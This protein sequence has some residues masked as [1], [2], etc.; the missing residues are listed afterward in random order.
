MDSGTKVRW[1]FAKW[2]DEYERGVDEYVQ[3][4]FA[5]KSQGNQICCPCES[6]HYRFW[7]HEGVVRDQLICNGFVPR[8][9]KLSELGISIER[10]QTILDNDEG[11]NPNDFNDDIVGLLHDARDDFRKGPNDE[12]KKFFKLVEEGQEELYLSCKNHSKHSFMIRIFILKCDHKPTNVA[13]GDILELIREVLPDAKL[14]ASFNE[15]KS[16]LKVLG[17]DYTKIDACPNDCMIYWEEHENATSCHVCETPRWKSN[18][19]ENG[20]QNENGKTYKIPQNILRYFP[21]KKRLQRLFM[22]QETARY[23][24]WH[25]DGREN[26]HLL[27]HPVDGQAWKEFDSLYP[28]F[29]DDPRN[30]RLG[31]A[32]DGF[33]PFNSMSIVHSTWPVMLINYNLPP[34]MIM[35]PEY[36]MLALLIP[37]PSSPGNDID[38]YLQPLIK[39]LKDLWEFGLETYDASTNQ[40]FDIHVAL[41]TIVSDFPGYAM[42]SGWSTKGYL[43]CPECHYETDSEWLLYSGKN[44][45]RAN[46]ISQKNKDNV[47]ARQDLVELNLM[48]ELQPIEF[49]DGSEEF[50]RSRFWMSLEQKHK[51][52]QVIKN[53]KLPQGYASNLSRCVQVR[54]RKIAGYKSHDA[55]FMMNYLLP[56]V[57]KTTLPK[58]VASPLIR[59]CAFFKGIWS[60]T[61]DPRDLGKLQSEIVKTLCLLERIFPPAFF[62]IMEHLP[63]HLVDQ[64]NEQKICVSAKRKRKWNSAEDHSKDFMDWFREKVDL[65]LKEGHDN[66]P[67]H[68]LWLSKGP[69][70]IAKKYTGYS[71]NG[72]RFHTMKRD[73]NCI[74]QNSGVTLIAITH[75]FASSKDQNP[76]L[77]NVNYYGSITEIIEISYHVHFS[78]VLFRCQW[79]H[80]IKD[81]DEL[82]TVNMNKTV[83]KEEPFILATQAHQVFY[84]E[85]LNRDGWHYA[86]QIPPRELSDGNRHEVVVS[87]SQVLEY[88]LQRLQKLK[89]N[90]EQMKAQGS[91]SLANKILSVAK[92]IIFER[93]ILEGVC[94]IMKPAPV[95]KLHNSYVRPRTTAVGEMNSQKKHH[96]D[97][98]H[99]IN[100]TK[101]TKKVHNQCIQKKQQEQ[102]VVSK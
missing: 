8:T 4:A 42:L 18:D 9:V 2:S 82:I 24:T 15:A 78:V 91:G 102:Q 45:Y 31:L 70:H 64:I 3:K 76:V 58:D 90:A 79:F 68:I 83:S 39:D 53:A 6:C 49:K 65:I 93:S 35:K 88:E 33:S 63:I 80:S 62:D 11:S 1:M 12:A 26:D 7:C 99:D 38:I 59:L 61:I 34:W 14:P 27:H 67:D 101:A 84:V 23:M 55:H 47:S 20:I 37:G 77:G 10:E 32:T 94:E 87:Q 89:S 95:S 43:A 41:M 13:F 17:L 46:H 16:V 21:I 74:T 72:Y 44:V 51:F 48:P 36:L 54:E 71:V 57:V 22:C 28:K 52:C 29:V 50:P 19:T 60:K 5:S 56:I 75:S 97:K 85:D 98:V 100:S 30:V 81:D 40:R 66:I 73:A 96:V 92:E 69:S 86:I 25:P